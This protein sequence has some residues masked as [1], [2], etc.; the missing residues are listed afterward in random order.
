MFYYLRVLY[1]SFV[2]IK[3]LIIEKIKEEAF[4]F[5]KEDFLKNPQNLIIDKV[6]FCL[7]IANYLFIFFLNF[8]NWL[9]NK[10]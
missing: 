1:K 6:F 7:K 3:L 2:I 4:F 9:I 8:N 5:V 10:N